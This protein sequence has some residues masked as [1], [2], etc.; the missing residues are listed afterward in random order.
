MNAARQP[1]PEPTELLLVA[2][3]WWGAKSVCDTVA[4]ENE[5]PANVFVVSPALTGH[6]I[7]SW[8]SHMNAPPR[9]ARLRAARVRARPTHATLEGRSS[10][11]HR[12][13]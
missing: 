12:C 2:D 1:L 10:N 6:P 4:R 8:R 5:H 7:H 3:A 11:G 13:N 9:G